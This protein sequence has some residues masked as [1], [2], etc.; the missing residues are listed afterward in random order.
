MGWLGRM[1]LMLRITHQHPQGN[2]VKISASRV[3]QRVGWLGRMSMLHITHQHHQ[4]NNV[5]TCSHQQS[6]ESDKRQVLE[7]G[8]TK[9]Q[10]W[11]IQH[12]WQHK[13]EK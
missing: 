12:S 1:L 11:S 6:K 8:H 9:V 13:E 10:V 5:Y 7:E 3:R 4:G 2:N